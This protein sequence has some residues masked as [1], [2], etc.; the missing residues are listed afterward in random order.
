MR[1]SRSPLPLIVV[2]LVLL[3]ALAGA[4]GCGDEPTT[5]PTS[6]S[7]R[8]SQIQSPEPWV[9]A[10]GS[11]IYDES[12]DVAVDPAGNVYV[13]GACN[14]PVDFG[15]GEVFDPANG[16]VF[17][18]KFDPVGEFLWVKRV[19]GAGPDG[20]LRLGTDRYGNVVL[21]GVFIRDLTVDGTTVMSAGGTDH[22]FLV[23]FDSAGNVRWIGY[24]SGQYMSVG[25]GM[26]AGA[27]GGTAVTGFI[28]A[29]AV[30]GDTELSVQGFDYFVVAYDA[31]GNVVWA[32]QSGSSTSAMGTEVA[33]DPGNNVI[34]A[35]EF[36]GAVTFGGTDLT[37]A[38]SR[39]AFITKYGP[40]GTVLWAVSIGEEGD[41]TAYGIAADHDSNVYVSGRLSGTTTTLWKLSPDGDLVWQ[42]DAPTADDLAV[43]RTGNVL[44]S[45]GFRGTMTVGDDVLTS[46]GFTDFFIA[47][48]DPS[49][50]G[51]WGVSGGASRDDCVQG[52]AVDSRGAPV[53]VVDF[54]ESFEFVG[55]TIT[56]RGEQDL[57]V[58]R[59]EP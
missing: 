36:R 52:L 2:L 12:H 29:G 48:Y 9:G 1:S 42:A 41:D 22:V 32:R 7:T 27:S 59:L 11:T 53:A 20:P 51:L 31:G 30:F 17:L 23:G 15:G 5:T 40:D 34:V 35:G 37:S 43:D 45:G 49:G 54:W 33:V 8:D 26:D 14:G 3:I 55:E 57:L 28:Q 19:S 24:D 39:D 21:Q 18:A 6:T 25:F 47:K 44:L 4:V 13:T 58:F 46:N 50:L 38:G 56:S 16:P 10:F